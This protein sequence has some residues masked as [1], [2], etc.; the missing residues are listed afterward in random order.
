MNSRHYDVVVIGAGVVGCA[1]A[2]QLARGGADVIVIE[3]RCDVGDG[4]SKANTAILPTGFDK[5][6]N[7]FESAM[8]LRGA[9]LLREF[10]ATRGIA[11][12][13][14]GGL[15]VAWD[16]EQ[17]DVLPQLQ[18]KAV[19]NHYHET[20]LL[21]PVQIY[22]KVPALGEGVTGGLF[23]PDES[24]IDPW[25]VT[26]AYAEEAV[27]RGVELQF[28]TRVT[29]VDVQPEQ[30][31]VTTTSGKVTATWVVNAAGLGSDAIDRQLGYER[32]TVTP[33]R[34]E[35][36]VFDKLARPLTPHIILPVP[37]AKGKGVLISPTVFGNVMLGPTAEDLQD[38][39]DTSTSRDGLRMLLEKGRKIMPSLLDEEIVA[40]YAGLR[41]ATEHTD[42]IVDIDHEQRYVCLGGIRSTGLVSSLALAEYVSQRLEP[43][44]V[45]DAPQ[46]DGAVAMPH[47]GE[48]Q[49]RP[50]QRAER[51]AENPEYGDIVCFCERVTHG[52]IKDALA[53]SVPPRDLDGL[54]RRTRAL[55]GRCGGFY[56]GA[57]VLDLLEEGT[58]P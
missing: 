47:I 53:S 46:T 20:Q 16:D 28:N 5:P 57:K 38:K 12:E 34:G 25:S 41:A 31:V 35:L 37:S 14:P 54:R 55:M 39:T 52:E 44:W 32:F 49:Q 2:R 43:E 58:K 13:K 51:I 18:A 17:A 7:S 50:Y 48:S 22:M 36:I 40:S 23:V 1:V 4:T 21:D 26:L 24:I 33:R 11:V 8:V 19:G 45:E 15:L 56:C 9:A 27:A 3:A 10:A 6:P 42:Y 29:T 30:T